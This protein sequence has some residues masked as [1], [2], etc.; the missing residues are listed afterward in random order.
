MLGFGR[1]QHL[2]LWR[3]FGLVFSGGAVVLGCTCGSSGGSAGPAASAT[4]VLDPEQAKRVLA[5]VGER[6]ITLGDFA[7][8][9]E[10]MDR[11]ERLRYQTADRR[12]LLLDEM[13]NTELLAREAERRG[14]DRLPSTQ[15]ALNQTP[16]FRRFTPRIPGNSLT[17]S[18]GESASLQSA[19]WTWRGK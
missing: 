8:A 12:K 19:V 10:R 4:G 9:L 18:Y 2:V 5:Q 17:R 1:G 16:R 3:T 13:I 7:Q 15:A 11:F 14:I 6:V